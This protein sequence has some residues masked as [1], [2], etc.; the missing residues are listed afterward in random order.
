M[1]ADLLSWLGN[2]PYAFLFLL[3]AL[4]IPL[5]PPAWRGLPYVAVPLLGL[6]LWAGG[7]V[8]EEIRVGY[9]GYELVLQKADALA[10][11]FALVFTLMLLIGGIYSWHVHDPAH[12]V[13]GM[14]YGG[15]ALGVVLAGD[16]L[17]LYLFWEMLAWSALYLIWA[18]RTERAQHAGQRYL[19]VHVFGGT[20]LL[21]GIWLSAS[22]EGS[23]AFGPFA[24]DAAASWLILLGFA[25]NAAIPPLHAWL[26]D[27]YPEATV[28]GSV[29]L[30]AFT[31][32]AAVYAL[33]RGFAGWDIL[34]WAGI[35]MALYGVFYAMLQNDARR[36][37]SYHIISQVGYM[38]AGIGLGT[39][40][41]VSGATA[42]AF[43]HVLYKALLFMGAGVLVHAA[44]TGKLTE[45]GSRIA[46]L[47]LARALYLVGAVSI[48]GFPLFSGFVS[49]TLVIAA[50][51]KGSLPAL[52]LLLELASVGTFLSVGLKLP[53]FAWQD[54]GQDKSYRPLR[55]VPVNMYIAMII[56]AWLSLLIGLFPHVFYRTLPY[57]VAYEPYTAT[58]VLE[59]LELFAFT[60]LA[61][62]LWAKK[63]A[64]EDILT[65]DTDWIYR[66]AVPWLA[67][68]VAEPLAR[69]N[70]RLDR[71]ADLLLEGSEHLARHPSLTASSL[72]VR[73]GV[74]ATLSV[75]AAL[76]GWLLLSAP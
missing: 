59:T 30:S 22:R 46:P 35:F 25:V 66:K 2:I 10:L 75:L 41:A 51:A 56:A 62:V 17:S 49:K 36:L 48:S 32:K 44:G 54:K 38:V 45:L 1:S 68:N 76:A 33:A 3:A 15:A 6:A 42:H 69:A 64:P 50:Y 12:Q 58:H 21:A 9:A 60:G 65:L 52:S 34:V 74:A 70:D 63:L 14:L 5:L 57:P 28:P 27:A 24:P 7:Y 18:S 37:L 47:R 53:Y 13:A 39:Q 61:F 26:P 8:A 19:L 55:A 11:P 40:L 23:L 71:I 67:R 73:A 20:L 43:A 31:T 72:P 29:F 4:V 16:L